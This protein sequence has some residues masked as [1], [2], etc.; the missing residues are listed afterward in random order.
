MHTHTHIHAH[1]PIHTHTHTQMIML[2]IYVVPWL[3][4][5]VEMTAALVYLFMNH[6]ALALL[7]A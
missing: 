5:K 4:H 7:C 1:T 6:I 2:S 3:P